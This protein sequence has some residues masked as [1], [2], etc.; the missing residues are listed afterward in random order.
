ME[1]C[2]VEAREGEGQGVGVMNCSNATFWIGLPMTTL[3]MEA[4]QIRLVPKMHLTWT[5]QS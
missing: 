2:P 1:E 3:E 5:R 4:G